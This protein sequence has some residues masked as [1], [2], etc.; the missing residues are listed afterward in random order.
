MSGTS[1]GPGGPY[2]TQSLV[3]GSQP[4]PAPPVALYVPE[5]L[6]QGASPEQLAEVARVQLAFAARVS[7]LLTTAYADIGRIVTPRSTAPSV[8]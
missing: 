3:I 8:A 2:K 1:G 5:T 4:A 7:E 6:L